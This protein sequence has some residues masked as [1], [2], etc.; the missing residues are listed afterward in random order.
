MRWCQL[1]ER[2]EIPAGFDLRS[3]VY[4]PSQWHGVSRY[5]LA[6]AHSFAQAA[7]CMK[8]IIVSEVR[9]DYCLTKGQINDHSRIP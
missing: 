8:E 4:A 7:G 5:M 1:H 9:C 2:A 3:R 6:L